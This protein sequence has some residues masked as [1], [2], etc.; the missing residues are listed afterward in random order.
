MSSW[1]AWTNPHDRLTVTVEGTDKWAEVND[2]LD[3]RGF[4]TG[5]LEVCEITTFDVFIASTAPQPAASGYVSALPS[6]F[7]VTGYSYRFKRR[8]A[9]KALQ[10][11]LTFGGA[12]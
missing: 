3:E 2:W 12:A 6:P 1:R 11:K 10:F 5:D 7:S 8:D 4:E 9:D